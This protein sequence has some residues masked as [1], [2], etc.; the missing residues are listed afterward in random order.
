MAHIVVTEVMDAVGLEMLSET[1]DVHYDPRLWD[2][3]ENLLKWVGKADALIVRNQTR[4]TSETLAVASSL[5]VV[6]RLGVGLDNIDVRAAH[7]RGIPVVTAQGANAV[8]VAEYV[9]AALFH[10]TRG[11]SAVDSTVR[12]GRWDRTL[13]GVE[14]FDKTLGLIG[15][16]DIGQRIAFR[17]RAFGMK[18]MAFD[19][20]RLPTHMASMDLGVHLTSLEEVMAESDFV[21]V[22]VPLTDATR[23]LINATALGRMKPT[24]YLINTARGGI[25]NEAELLE[26]IQNG[27]IGGA[28]LDVRNVEPM[29]GEDPLAADRR[30]LLTPHISGLTREAGLRTAIIVAEDVK[31]VL[32]G[33]APVASV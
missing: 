29:A 12:A 31:R 11:L 24:A 21:S 28:A 33:Q 23:G 5:K 14:L 25:V 32:S 2:Q 18:V 9:F 3:P 6:G 30:I 8:A 10:F 4:V 17:A 1:F 19:P 20:W 26:T 22:H 27:G 16:G 13:G 7:T 15:M